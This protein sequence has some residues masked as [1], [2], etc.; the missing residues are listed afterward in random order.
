MLDYW[1]QKLRGPLP[2]LEL[3]TDHTRPAF[4][5]F[6]GGEEGIDLSPQLSNAI[7]DLSRK[8]NA[9]LFVT[10]LAAFYALLHLYTRQQNVIVGSGFANRSMKEIEQLIGMVI[11]T[12]A[13]RV[14]LTGN[15]TFHELIARVR[16]VVSEAQIHQEL[17]FEFLVQELRPGRDL[18]YNPLSGVRSTCASNSSLM[19]RS[20]GYFDAVSFHSTRI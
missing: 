5:S 6:R 11:N 18:S 17:P 7:R 1:K 4:Q 19:H 12:V 8:E 9:T 13:L 20:L 3:T 16:K 2:V 14:D 15:P 10:M